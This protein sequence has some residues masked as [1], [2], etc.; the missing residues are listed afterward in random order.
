MH[1]LVG[2]IGVGISHGGGTVIK[3]P[4]RRKCLLSA[5]TGKGAEN[6]KFSAEKSIIH[7]TVIV[8]LKR[9][10][11]RIIIIYFLTEIHIAGGTC[12]IK[13]A[14]IADAVFAD[15]KRNMLIKRVGSF[16][17]ISHTVGCFYLKIFAR[18]I[19]KAGFI[20]ETENLFV[21]LS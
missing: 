1:L 2:I 5:N 16:G 4:F 9:L 13:N 21:F 19:H 3:T 15:I 8:G 10:K 12:I 7:Y 6:F 20:A 17:V 11:S 14:V 18:L